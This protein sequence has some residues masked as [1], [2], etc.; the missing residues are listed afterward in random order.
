MKYSWILIVI[1]IALAVT[2]LFIV[3]DSEFGGADGL[4]EETITEVNP[5]YE[6]WFTPL[7]EPPGGETESLLFALQAALGAGFLGYY[8][9]LK[10][11]QAKVAS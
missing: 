2:P 1:V 9:G 8:F 3:Q 4:A 5:T 7:W 6:P 11:G 10:K